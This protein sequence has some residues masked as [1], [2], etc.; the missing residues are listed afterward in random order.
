[1]SQWRSPGFWP[2]GPSNVKVSQCGSTGGGVDSALVKPPRVVFQPSGW[3][4]AT[5]LWVTTSRA[6]PM[7]LGHG[8]N[9]HI[10]QEFPVFASLKTFIQNL[11][12]SVFSIQIPRMS[13]VPSASTP[14]ANRDGLVAHH[15]ARILRAV[16]SSTKHTP[17]RMNAVT[18][19]AKD[20][21]YISAC[22]YRHG[23]APGV[24]GVSCRK[25]Q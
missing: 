24:H 3:F 20:L 6:S 12:P 7:P 9:Q 16:K 14:R 2:H 8:R 11:A 18:D 23:H 19:H 13:R 22:R 17:C 10:K 15:T 4:A 21:P 5:C 1:M 25:N